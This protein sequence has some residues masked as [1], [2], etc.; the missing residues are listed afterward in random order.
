VSAA[1]APLGALADELAR[2]AREQRPRLVELVLSLAALDAP[3]A[4]ARR[5][6][7][8]GGA[9]SA[10][11]AAAGGTARLTAPGRRQRGARRTA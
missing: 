4:G 11:R 9:R 10:D 2:G 5:A 1:A 3:S 8:T 6:R 7:L